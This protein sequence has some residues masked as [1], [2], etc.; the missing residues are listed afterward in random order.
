MVV[1]GA[2]PWLGKAV[3]K[4]GDRGSKGMGQQPKTLPCILESAWS[5][6]ARV[7]EA[8]WIRCWAGFQYTWAFF[9]KFPSELAS[10]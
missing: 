2:G 9:P 4:I 3:V 6:L 7:W 1:G 10:L 8:V 5:F